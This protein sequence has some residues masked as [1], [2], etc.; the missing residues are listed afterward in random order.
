MPSKREQVL[1]SLFAR[2]QTLE[3]PTVRVYRNQDKPQ[4]IEGGM[5]ILRDGTSGEP[6]V[7][8]SPLTYIYEHRA[9]IEIMV[10]APDAAD[11]DS[12]LDALLSDIGAVIASDRSLS[13]LAEWAE[14]DAP[15][16]TEEPIEGALTVKMAEIAI[17]VRFATHDPLN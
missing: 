6:E 4:K 11:R 10:Q 3:S 9:N 14:A 8:L 17:M 13:G 15:D 16:F 1:L 12:A 2:L 5:I 7:L